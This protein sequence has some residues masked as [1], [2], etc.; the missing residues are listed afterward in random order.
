[1]A[2]LEVFD[3]LPRRPKPW[4]LLWPLRIL[5]LLGVLA[6]WFV[7]AIDG[8]DVDTTEVEESASNPPM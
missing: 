1:M 4:W 3:A 8:S 5:A 7:M 6:F 2:D